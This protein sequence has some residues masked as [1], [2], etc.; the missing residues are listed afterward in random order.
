[1]QLSASTAPPMAAAPAATALPCAIPTVAMPVASKPSPRPLGK[2]ALAQMPVTF[3]TAEQSAGAMP[4]ILCYGDSL[5]VGFASGG[6]AFEPYG[7]AL[8]DAMAE[9]G[10]VCEVAVCGH[11]GKTARDMVAGLDSGLSDMAGLHG[12]G[13]RRI[14]RE[15]GPW[16]LVLIMA[17]TN[18]IGY[19]H[20]L[21]DIVA[22][23]RRLHM[24]CHELGVGTGL[25]PP[26]SAPCGDARWQAT[27]RQVKFRLEELAEGMPGIVGVV[28]P[29]TIVPPTLGSTSASA[30]CWDP[31]NLHFSP[32]GSRRLGRDL[33]P[34]IVNSMLRPQRATLAAAARV[35]PLP[36]T[37]A[38][39]VTV[40]LDVP[41]S[42]AAAAAAAATAALS[43]AAPAPPA[44]LTASTAIM[45]AMA[46]NDV[47]AQI[48]PLIAAS[49]ALGGSTAASF[50]VPS[51]PKHRS[52]SS[53]S[54]SISAT[55]ATAAAA[56]TRTTQTAT[57]AS[58]SPR[59]PIGV[60]RMVSCHVE[61]VEKGSRP[62]RDAAILVQ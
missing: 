37:G 26:P 11:S 40:S 4:R 57:A 10:T 9:L 61:V 13:L 12:K 30:W 39:T 17:G 42:A 41:V 43:V 19:D 5:T 51:V 18:D 21:E 45:P 22:D 35:R 62:E 56:G 24:V 38:T 59:K 34:R 25:L 2:A 29:S 27:R 47:S 23:V 3:G 31:D 53:S 44:T 6:N 28:D 1:M 55:A 54:I 52:G 14:L 46:S 16:D 58:T 15:D 7:R 20:A 60:R 48:E 33:A 8:S 49:S 36:T 50:G 32:A